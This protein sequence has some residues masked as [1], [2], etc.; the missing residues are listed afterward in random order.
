MV[1]FLLHLRGY[2]QHCVRHLLHCP[3]ISQG[4]QLLYAGIGL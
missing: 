4:K 3:Q 2:Q 1:F